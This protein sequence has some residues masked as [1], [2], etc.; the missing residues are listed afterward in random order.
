MSRELNH[1][2]EHPCKCDQRHAV[3]S[4]EDFE[5]IKRCYYESTRFY[6]CRRCDAQWRIVEW[7]VA[8]HSTIHIDREPFE[9]EEEEE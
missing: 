4:N 1:D 7:C 2:E 8:Q 5:H 6:F 3:L 9:F